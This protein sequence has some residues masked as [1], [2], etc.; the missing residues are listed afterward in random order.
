MG[1]NYYLHVKKDFDPLHRIPARLGCSEGDENEPLELVNGWVWNKKY[2]PTIEDLNKEFYQVLHIGKSSMGWRFGLCIYPTE[3]PR[4]K[5]D[6]TYHE[7]WLD[8]PIN[9]LEDWIKLFKTK[10]N[11]IFNE[12]NEEVS[13]KEML[14]T[15]TKRQGKVVADDGS[16]TGTV[17]ANSVE[18][19]KVVAGLLVHTPEDKYRSGYVTMMPANCTYDLLLSGNDPNSGIIFS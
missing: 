2:Y 17:T 3:N 5:D 14:K 13:V 4:F 8:E 1:T 11:R 16:D 19:Y 18:E 10:G 9:S 15:I 7:Y 6:S 12:Y